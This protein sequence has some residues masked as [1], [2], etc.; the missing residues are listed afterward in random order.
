MPAPVETMEA[1]AD[2]LVLELGRMSRQWP[3]ATLSSVFLGGGTPSIMPAKALSRVLGAVREGFELLPN[4][5][6]TSEA[7]PGTLEA[8]WLSTAMACGLNRLSLGVQAAQDALLSA[9]GRV[10]TFEEAQS[11]V[12]LARACGVENLNLDLMFGLPGQ[13]LSD[14]RAT[15]EAAAALRP[16][17]LSAYS[18]ILEP[19]TPLYDAVMAGRV[20]LPT[21]DETADMYE[22]G[23][24][25][26]ADAGFRRYEISNF[27]RPGYE[28]RHNLGYWRGAYYLGAGAAAHG[29][30]PPRDEGQA[31]L[32][33]GNAPDVDAY[34]RALLA[35][36]PPPA[37]ETPVTPR[38]AMFETMML[39]LRTT[40]G[41][42]EAEFAG[43]HGVALRARYGQ[44]LDGLAADGLGRFEAGRFFLTARGLAL[45]ND[46]LLR[47][48]D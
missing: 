39:S 33:Y 22:Q 7:N 23:I 17:H 16:E 34:I 48:M 20:A 14:Y 43:K 25:W 44:A 4:A 27:A 46:A 26:L 32:R 18:L 19:N 10:H 36:N 45:Q 47:L 35:G 31:Y 9:I 40:T 41:V 21:E 42:S 3:G 8:E 2:A 12:A 28:C 11:A 37:Q 6:F 13:R 5:E 15:V 1:Y 38:E 24:A 30:L 29:M